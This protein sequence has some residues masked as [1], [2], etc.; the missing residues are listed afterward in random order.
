MNIVIRAGLLL[1]LVASLSACGVQMRVQYGTPVGY[2]THQNK[3][4]AAV[5]HYGLQVDLTRQEIVGQRD[6]VTERL[7][8]Q[9]YRFVPRDV[10]CFRHPVPQGSTVSVCSTDR[11]L[12]LLLRY[13]H[14]GYHRA[15]RLTLAP[16]HPLRDT[17]VY[18][19]FSLNDGWYR[20]RHHYQ[21]H[22][23]PH[24]HNQY[25]DHNHNQYLRRY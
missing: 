24:N 19:S 2:L 22:H 7:L 23:H 4:E 3:Q 6:G 15:V 25:Y 20:D 14:R 18:T 9:H 13:Y 8:L 1:L 10:M 21:H 16:P 5:K 12:N 11:Q 17:P